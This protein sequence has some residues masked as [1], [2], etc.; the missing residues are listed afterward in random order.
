MYPRFPLLAVVHYHSSSAGA[1]HN[2][3][4]V[5]ADPEPEDE[6]RPNYRDDD[7]EEEP[8]EP[9]SEARSKAEG[10]ARRVEVIE[11]FNEVN[12]Y[13]LNNPTSP[14]DHRAL[15]LTLRCVSPF[16]YWLEEENVEILV[17]DG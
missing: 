9:L 8:R 16:Q 15:L 1:I 4:I 14:T 3:A 6:G 10:E 12:A 2:L 13:N 5:L 11:S 7:D 17:Q